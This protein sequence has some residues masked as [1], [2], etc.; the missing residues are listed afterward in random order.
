ME[1]LH[2]FSSG[3]FHLL[4]ASSNFLQLPDCGPTT[5]TNV[6][7]I[8]RSKIAILVKHSR[9][10]GPFLASLVVM[11]KGGSIWENKNLACFTQGTQF[12]WNLLSSDSDW[13]TFLN[14]SSTAE[15]KVTLWRGNENGKEIVLQGCKGLVKDMS[16]ELPYLILLSRDHDFRMNYIS[17]YRVTADN[18]EEVNANAFMVKSIGIENYS[19]DCGMSFIS[20]KFF[21]GCV[22]WLPNGVFVNLFESALLFH[23]AVPPEKLERR[24][25]RMPGIFFNFE[26]NMNSTSLVTV[27]YE[28]DEQGKQI[29]QL[30]KRDFWMSNKVF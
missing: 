27:K 22:Q 28:R 16:M 2:C 9:R 5:V 20:N 24:Q 15:K 26:V 8:D 30:V 25:I 23:P 29:E 3:N 6:Q 4:D 10:S 14:T 18:L 13:L 19:F 17:V 21:L 7:V 11:K 1:Q 12:V